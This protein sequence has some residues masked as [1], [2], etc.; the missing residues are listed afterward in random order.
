MTD[1]NVTE[2]EVL[3]EDHVSSKIAVEESMEWSELIFQT[4]FE[5]EKKYSRSIKKKEVVNV[6]EAEDD[7]SKVSNAYLYLKNQKENLI[8]SALYE[9]FIDMSELRE[10]SYL[11]QILYPEKRLEDFARNIAKM[12]RAVFYTA[13]KNKINIKNV[14]EI[15]TK[16]IIDLQS[17]EQLVKFIMKYQSFITPLKNIHLSKGDIMKI[18]SEIISKL[19]NKKIK[20]DDLESI[21]STAEAEFLSKMISEKRIQVIQEGDELVFTLLDEEKLEEG[22]SSSVLLS[23]KKKEQESEKTWKKLIRRMIPIQNRN[24]K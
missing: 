23:P 12:C 20:K 21:L 2:E 13:S 9:E 22:I 16:D 18:E 5:L 24:Q 7:R 17:E 4:L 6:K 14:S 15:F 3:N 8:D 11:E 1:P 10:I 19:R